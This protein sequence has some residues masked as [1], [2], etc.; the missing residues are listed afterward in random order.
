MLMLGAKMRNR[1]ETKLRSVPALLELSLHY[2][3]LIDGVDQNG[4]QIHLDRYEELA[5][6]YRER[7]AN[8]GRVVE[9]VPMFG[10]SARH[11]YGTFGSTSE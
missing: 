1:S 5:R 8:P 11:R 2:L 10:Y 7:Y 6:R 4:A 9:P 3:C